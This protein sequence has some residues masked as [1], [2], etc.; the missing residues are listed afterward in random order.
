MI[1]FSTHR[2]DMVEKV[3]TRAVILSKGR[4]VAERVI[5]REREASAER[6]AERESLEAMFHRVTAQQDFSPIAREILSVVQ[7]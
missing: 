6:P 3:C 2:F 7:A 5:Q 1:L 4:I